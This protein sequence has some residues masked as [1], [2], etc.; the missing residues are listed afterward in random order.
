MKPLFWKKML[1]SSTSW[2]RKCSASS[3]TL[4]YVLSFFRVVQNLFSLAV[5]TRSHKGMLRL[6]LLLKL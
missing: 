3:T 5:M 6:L 1:N 2:H 4:L